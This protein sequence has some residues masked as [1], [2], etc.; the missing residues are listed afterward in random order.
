MRLKDVLKEVQDVESTF[1]DEE[2]STDVSVEWVEKIES[3][4]P[5]RQK[6]KAPIG[7][8]LGKMIGPLY[9]IIYTPTGHV[10]LTIDTRKPRNYI[11]KIDI[12][13]PDKVIQEDGAKSFAYLNIANGIVDAFI[14]SGKVGLPELQIITKNTLRDGSKKATFGDKMILSQ[15]KPTIILKKEENVEGDTLEVV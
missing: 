2:K 5:F 14:R 15:L 12:G 13:E 6:G 9:N 10:Y 1:E 3:R 11:I 4:L 7:L 8:F